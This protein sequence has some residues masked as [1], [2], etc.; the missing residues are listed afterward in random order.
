VVLRGV[1][2]SLA[3]LT[4]G[5]VVIGVGLNAFYRTAPMVDVTR[6][7]PRFDPAVGN[8]PAPFPAPTARP[9]TT[10]SSTPAGPSASTSAPPP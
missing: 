2:A 10:P 7:L 5:V 9:S 8:G 4:L 1:A 3:L 6:L